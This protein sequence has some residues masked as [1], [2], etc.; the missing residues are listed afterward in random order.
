M[1]L[2]FFFRFGPWYNDLQYP[3]L[4]QS[5]Q[6]MCEHLIATIIITAH[7]FSAASLLLCNELH[8]IN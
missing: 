6:E 8:P 5:K 7:I 1:Y 4:A 2:L 3:N